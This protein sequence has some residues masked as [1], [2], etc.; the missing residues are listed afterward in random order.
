MTWLDTNLVPCW[1][2]WFCVWAALLSHA[3]GGLSITPRSLMFCHV[4]S[5]LV[6]TLCC[7]PKMC[8]ADRWSFPRPRH[9]ETYPDTQSCSLLYC[10]WH[11]HLVMLSPGMWLQGDVMPSLLMAYSATHHHSGWKPLRLVQNG[12]VSTRASISPR[13]LGLYPSFLQSEVLCFPMLL[14]NRCV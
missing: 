11:A 3:T 7:V 13:V 8:T 1:R 12:D 4:S 10:R 6:K 2:Y 14:P 5:R 9:P